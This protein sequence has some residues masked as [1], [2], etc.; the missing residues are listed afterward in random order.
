M[1]AS[2]TIKKR[3]AGPTDGE[4]VTVIGAL[5]VQSLLSLPIISLVKAA[6]SDLT[7]LEELGN[8]ADELKHLV[9]EEIAAVKETEEQ[10]ER[11]ELRASAMESGLCGECNEVEKVSL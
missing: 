3:K 2:T 8:F 1:S 5:Q 7:R 6:Q 10:R 11:N 4:T 9:D